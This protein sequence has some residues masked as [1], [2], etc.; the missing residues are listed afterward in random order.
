MR[1]HSPRRPPESQQGRDW[2]DLSHD[3]ATGIET[4]RAHFTGHAYDPHFD[5][6]RLAT[7]IRR[8]FWMLHRPEVRLARDGALDALAA[9][10]TPHFGVS[11][12]ARVGG[13]GCRRGI[14]RSESLG[15]LVPPCVRVD[16]RG[17]PRNLHKLFRRAVPAPLRMGLHS[18]GN[19]HV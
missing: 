2:V 12:V 13:G 11:A 14:R 4:I 6:P 7:A 8:A 10:L 15:P 19:H 9:A 3:S 5:E 18:G 17:L 16:P 1:L